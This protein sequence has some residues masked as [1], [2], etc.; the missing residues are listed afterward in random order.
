MGIIIE[1]VILRSQPFDNYRS[2]MDVKDIV[3]HVVRRES[4][5]FRPK[6]QKSPECPSGLYHLMEC[7]WAD[8]PE[9]RPSFNTV[10]KTIKQ[11]QGKKHDNIVE[12]LISRLEKYATNL[13]EIVDERTQQLVVEKKRSETLLYQ[14]LPASVANQLRQG[15]PVIPEAFQAV[16]IYFSDIIGFTS[17][18]ASSSP[19][20]IVTFLNDL[21]SLFDKVIDNY[22]VYKV[23]TIGD[24]YMVVSGL[25]IRNGLRHAMEICRMALALLTDVK[26]FVIK[27]RPEEKLQVRIGVNSGPCAAGVVGVKMPRYCLFGDTVNTASRLESTGEASMIHISSSTKSILDQCGHFKTEN[28]GEIFLKGKGSEVTYWLLGEERK[29]KAATLTQQ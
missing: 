6:V 18:C 14:I 11:L 12:A 1:E 23:E 19:M 21:Y 22:D 5:P 26:A 4:P 27:H 17:I 7:C 20:D 13:E 2:T 8:N 16:T 10:E 29:E 9:E 25:P 15:R 24:A 28:R 3:S